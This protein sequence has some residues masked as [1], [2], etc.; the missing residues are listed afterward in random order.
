MQKYKWKVRFDL[1][2]NNLK[3]HQYYNQYFL[4]CMQFLDQRLR[5]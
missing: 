3:G 5:K 1:Y 4:V 2:K